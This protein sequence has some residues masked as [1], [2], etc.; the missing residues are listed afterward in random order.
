MIKKLILLT[1]FCLSFSNSWSEGKDVFLDCNTKDTDN[2][3]IINNVWVIHT[4]SETIP[5]GWVARVNE[6]DGK[7]ELENGYLISDN[8]VRIDG[9]GWI[10]RTTLEVREFNYDELFPKY[11]NTGNIIGQCR[12]LDIYEMREKIKKM[13]DEF[14]DERQF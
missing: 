11:F 1:A 7:L 2:Q 8:D 9:F 14:V 13:I 5:E 3:N 12:I 6:S 4:P 10:D